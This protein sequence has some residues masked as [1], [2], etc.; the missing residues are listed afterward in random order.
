MRSP[1]AFLSPRIVEWIVQVLWST[2]G[3]V[4]EKHALNAAGPL[5]NRANKSGPHSQSRAK[6]RQNWLTHSERLSHCSQNGWRELGS[7]TAIH[8]HLHGC[9]TGAS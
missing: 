9:G 7:L 8:H 2:R 5:E 6:R 1:D 4:M 3:G